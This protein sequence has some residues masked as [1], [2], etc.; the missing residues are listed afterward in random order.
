VSTPRTI[1]VRPGLLVTLSTRLEGGVEYRRE[2]LE[3]EMQGASERTEW[4]T[5]KVVAD[6]AEHEAATRVRGRVRS[7]VRSACCWSPFGLICPTDTQ[8]SCSGC[9]RP[10]AECGCDVPQ[11]TDSLA[12]DLRIREAHALCEEFNAGAQ[13]TRVRFATMRGRIAENTR[14]AVQA[15]REEIQ[16]LLGELQQAIGAGEVQGIRDVAQKATQMGRLLEEG[17]EARTVLDRAVKESRRV[18]TEL[19]KRVEEGATAAAEILATA[20]VSL[21]AMARHT[22]GDDELGD[23]AEGGPSLPSTALARFGDLGEDYVEPPPA[24]VIPEFTEEERDAFGRLYERTPEEYFA[25]CAGQE[26]LESSVREDL[27]RFMREEA[28][29]AAALES[30]PAPAAPT[31]PDGPEEYDEEEI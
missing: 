24:P 20:N 14:E 27:A 19:V 15:V 8:Q 26:D 10:L 7:L 25:D 31:A 16:I 23:I 30:E 4:K 28:E 12:L 2:D 18:A 21:I 29:E 9:E 3:Q 6:K 17:T 1:K 5:E 11:P 13:H 22:F